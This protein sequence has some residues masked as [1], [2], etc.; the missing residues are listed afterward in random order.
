MAFI[1]LCCRFLN[2]IDCRHVFCATPI[3]SATLGAG[4]DPQFVGMICSRV[5]TRRPTGWRTRPSCGSVILSSSGMTGNRPS[6]LLDLRVHE[7]VDVDGCYE[8][9]LISYAVE[10]DERAHAFLA[11]PYGLSAPAPALVSLHGTYPHGKEREAG[12]RRIRRRPFSITGAA[13]LC[14]DRTRSFRGRWS[15]IPP[16]GAYDTARF[17]MKNIPSG[18]RSARRPMSMPSRLMCCKRSPQWT[19]R[20]SA[21]SAIHSAGMGRIFLPPTIRASGWPCRIPAAPRSATITRSRHGRD[22][23][24]YLPQADP[25]GAAAR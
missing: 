1:F 20:A 12:F 16:E 14:G 11:V 5:C 8:R 6:L 4:T 17:S 19:R 23:F 10:A 9:R 21:C 7:V 15:P 24:L 13:R 25:R 2:V 18:R 22:S 3:A